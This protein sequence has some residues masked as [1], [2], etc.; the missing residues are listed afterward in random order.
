MSSFVGHHVSPSSV[1][2]RNT[3][4]SWQTVVILF[5]GFFASFTQ[6]LAFTEVEQKLVRKH[7]TPLQF[8]LGHFEY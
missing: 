1:Q 2:S 4:H 3:L 7:K 8:D 5:I 6:Y